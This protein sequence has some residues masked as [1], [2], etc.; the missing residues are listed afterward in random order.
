MR[1]KQKDHLA[2]QQ[3]ATRL[4]RDEKRALAVILLGVV[5]FAVSMATMGGDT[6]GVD[7]S[8]ERMSIQFE[9]WVTLDGR[10]LPSVTALVGIAIAVLGIVLGNRAYARRP[11]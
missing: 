2:R 8:R 5:V 10:P 11:G 6:A 1:R 7:S 4:T 3:R 9:A